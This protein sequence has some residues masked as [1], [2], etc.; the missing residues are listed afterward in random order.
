M[1]PYMCTTISVITDMSLG[2]I[3]TFL[4]NKYK[5]ATKNERT[6][7]LFC[8]ARER[9][10]GVDIAE[11]ICPVSYTL[12]KEMLFLYLTVKK[13]FLKLVKFIHFRKQRF[14]SYAVGYAKSRIIYVCAYAFYLYT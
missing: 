8:L 14:L 1:V 12:R 10:S 5:L 3:Y 11:V 6:L 2:S 7:P 4:L 9:K 13:F